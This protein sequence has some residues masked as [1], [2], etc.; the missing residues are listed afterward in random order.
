MKKILPLLLLLLF[1]T[2]MA[3][4]GATLSFVKPPKSFCYRVYFSDKKHNIY[5]TKRPESFLSEKALER[6]KKFKIKVDE[7]DLPVTPFYLEY[8]N[9]HQFKVRNVSK[10]N[11]TAVV[12][13]TD[14]ASLKTLAG[15]YFVDHITKVWESPDSIAVRPKV[16]R[17]ELVE[18][19]RD[20][21][22]EYYGCGQ[23]QIDMLQAA[24]LH[25]EGYN[26][27]GMTI[28]VIDGGFYNADCIDGLKDCNILGTHNF[29]K[30]GQSVYEETQQHGTMVLSCIAAN[31]PYSM[32]GTA[33]NASFYLLQSEDNDSESLMEED[34][35]CAA[36]EYADSIG[37]DIVTSSLGYYKFDDKT[38]SH[39]Y[40]EQNGTT[41]VNSYCASL[42]A[43]RGLLILN[44]AGNEGDGT[45]KKIGF[46]GDA[47]DILTVGAV[48]KDSVNTL[49]SSIGNTADGRIKPDV[50]A[51]G[52]SSA[53]LN[54]NGNVTTAN[55]TSFSTPILC[56]AVACLWQAFPKAKPTEIIEAVQKAGNNTAHPNNIFGYGIPDMW[57]AYEFLKNK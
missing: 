16:S 2:A 21:L 14:T 15:L 7:H 5:S 1:T 29:V 48:N 27:K 51:Q 54:C 10:W 9:N 13:L 26:G 28:A 42:A 34:N 22:A 12:E 11:N 18:N 8:L 36:V 49:F 37:A 41:A 17:F 6:R 46:P 39:K 19:R 4:E 55:G 31:L 25:E 43:S 33:P 40:H 3:D 44:S 38:T 57:K 45:W 52:E 50:M 30:P 23:H 47:K 24:R 32:V 20:T 53:L 56:G 35:W